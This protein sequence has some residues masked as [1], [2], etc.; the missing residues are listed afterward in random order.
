MREQHSAAPHCTAPHSVA[1]PQPNSMRPWVTSYARVS[2]R[3]APA[4][5]GRCSGVSGSLHRSGGAKHPAVGTASSR[6]LEAYR[7]KAYQPPWKVPPP[8]GTSTWTASRPRG[9]VSTASCSFAL[10]SRELLSGR[11]GD[12]ASAR[13][14]HGHPIRTTSSHV[15]CLRSLA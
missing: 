10:A 6:R 15:D 2:E 11:L 12:E 9:L 4:W 14:R 13:T 3:V 5:Q 1:S 8:L 7:S